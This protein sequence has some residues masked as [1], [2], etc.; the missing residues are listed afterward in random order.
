MG[1][2]VLEQQDGSSNSGRTVIVASFGIMG[3]LLPIECYE[4]PRSLLQTE[5]VRDYYT[6]II[7]CGRTHQ[8]SDILLL[9]HCYQDRTNQPP[10]HQSR[11]IPLL[12][13]LVELGCLKLY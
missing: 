11:L 4:L 2:T 12:G 3:Y 6:C 13:I 9:P 5:E 7:E 1:R 8:R 10:Q